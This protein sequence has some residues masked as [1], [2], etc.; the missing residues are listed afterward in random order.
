MFRSTADVHLHLPVTSSKG[1]EA[2]EQAAP[3]DQEKPMFRPLLTIVMLSFALTLAATTLPNRP[4]Q[5]LDLVRYSGQWHEIAHLPTFFQRR[6]LDAVTAT[7]TAEPDGS[8]HVNNRCRTSDGIKVIDGVAKVETGHPGAFKVRFAPAW[9]T[10]LPQAWISC[11]VIDVDAGYQWAV[12]GGP[13]RKRL[14]ILARKDSMDR[15][16]FERIREH[17]RQRG[18][19]VGQL[20]MMAPLD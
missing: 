2:H 12:V 13:D 9:L 19:A 3:Q 16:L 5:T 1:W 17:A 11:W 18:Y 20:V 6:C 10:W 14:W 7:Y 4:V 15:G 8:I